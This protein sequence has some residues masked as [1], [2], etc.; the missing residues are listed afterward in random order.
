[1]KYINKMKIVFGITTGISF[2]LGISISCQ[3]AMAQSRRYPSEQEVESIQATFKKRLPSLLETRTYGV[4]RRSKKEQE[5]R[6]DFVRAWSQVNPL[7][8]KFFGEWTAIE[9]RVAIYPSTIKNHVCIVSLDNHTFRDGILKGS[10]V[11]SDGKSIWFIDGGLLA[12]ANVIDSAS[13]Q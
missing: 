5:K 9:E 8:A 13:N 12:I 4:E 10:I 7:S 6:E 2:L 3:N 11:Y 1:M